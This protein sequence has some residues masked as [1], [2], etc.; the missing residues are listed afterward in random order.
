[1][2]RFPSLNENKLVFKNQVPLV[3]LTFLFMQWEGWLYMYQMQKKLS[4]HFY[5][6]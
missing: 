1:M 6:Q 4:A 5:K 2:C 3:G